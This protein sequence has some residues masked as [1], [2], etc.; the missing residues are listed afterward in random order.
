MHA[1]CWRSMPDADAGCS[2]YLEAHV[3]SRSR[4]DCE[5]Q[6]GS[7]RGLQRQ[8]WQQQKQEL[9]L[10]RVMQAVCDL[11]KLEGVLVGGSVDHLQ[12][13]AAWSTAHS[14]THSWL[15]TL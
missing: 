5:P 2:A 9:V 12:Q 14:R 15:N 7:L 11:G 1:C 13:Q 10:A 3:G 8:G 4:C 6:L